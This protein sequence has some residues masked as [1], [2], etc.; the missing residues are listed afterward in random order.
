MQV[1]EKTKSVVDKGCVS[2][3]ELDQEDPTSQ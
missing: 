3:D 2:E 1:E